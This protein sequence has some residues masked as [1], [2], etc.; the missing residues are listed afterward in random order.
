MP[1]RAAV[2]IPI[3]QV[4][5]VLLTEPAADLGVGC[6]RIGDVCGDTSLV[7][8]E[9]FFATEIPAVSNDGQL[10]HAGRFAQLVPDLLAN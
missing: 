7:A 10:F 3:G 2:L 5:D 6:E 8:C 4:N 9:D 1:G